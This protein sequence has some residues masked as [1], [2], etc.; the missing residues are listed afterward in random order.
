MQHVSLDVTQTQDRKQ[1]SNWQKQNLLYKVAR[2]HT[3]TSAILQLAK[4]SKFNVKHCILQTF[5]ATLCKYIS[6]NVQ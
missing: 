5:M 2:S 1:T 3:D 4:I 6:R